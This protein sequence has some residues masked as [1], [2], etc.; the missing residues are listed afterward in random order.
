MRSA[1]D[2][3]RV[4][5]ELQGQSVTWEYHGETICRGHLFLDYDSVTQRSLAKSMACAEGDEPEKGE[6]S[7]PECT[8]TTDLVHIPRLVVVEEY[9]TTA[10]D[11]I[12]ILLV[13][14][15]RLPPPWSDTTIRGHLPRLLLSSINMRQEYPTCPH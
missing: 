8:S 1:E 9:L 7:R 15:S 3:Q 14:R 12:L 13:P 11:E 6:A 4:V 5:K 10:Q 2:C